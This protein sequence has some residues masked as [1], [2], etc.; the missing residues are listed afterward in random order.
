MDKE[1]I[2]RMIRE[3]V[4]EEVARASSFR[5]WD[6]KDTPT[7]AY[8]VVNRNY[9]NLSGTVAARPIGSVATVGQRYFATDT[10]TPMVYTGTNWRNGVGSVVAST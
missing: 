4:R 3:A 7:D 5:S 8:S 1:H 9:V 6:R 10:G 2:M